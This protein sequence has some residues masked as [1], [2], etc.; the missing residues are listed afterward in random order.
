MKGG[1]RLKT[2]SITKVFRR[3]IETEHLETSGS[4]EPVRV[5]DSIDETPG[6]SHSPRL[7]TKSD[8]DQDQRRRLVQSKRE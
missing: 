4:S 2:V 1:V 3:P 6:A 8:H 7:S 5:I